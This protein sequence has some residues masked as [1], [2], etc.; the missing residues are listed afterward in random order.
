MYEHIPETA[1]EVITRAE[2]EGKALHTVE[3][4]LLGV[5]VLELGAALAKHWQLPESLCNLTRYQDQPELSEEKQEAA[6][7]FVAKQ[8]AGTV[9]EPKLVKIEL[10]V[11]DFTLRLQQ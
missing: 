8:L 1:E 6:I 4:E 7:I 5:N 9:P 10:E 11:S 2:V 3:T